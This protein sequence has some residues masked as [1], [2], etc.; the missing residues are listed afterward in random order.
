V[1]RT[2]IL[3]VVVAAHNDEQP[4]AGFRRG[5]CETGKA[6]RRTLFETGRTLL[7]TE[8]RSSGADAGLVRRSAARLDSTARAENGRFPANPASLT[9]RYRNR[10][11]TPNLWASAR[12]ISACRAVAGLAQEAD[13][14][15]PLL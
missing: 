13:A 14:G 12:A 3:L 5:L 10:Q 4:N 2:E 11:N 9:N 7:E 6:V 15:L 1:L 8:A